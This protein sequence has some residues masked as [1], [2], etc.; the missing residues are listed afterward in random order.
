MELLPWPCN[1]WETHS[2]A[3]S[4]RLPHRHLAQGSA[5]SP[6][7]GA[8]AQFALFA[9]QCVL[10]ETVLLTVI[11]AKV[12]AVES[13]TGIRSPYLLL[14]EHGMLDA[15]EGIYAQRHGPADAVKGQDTG[16]SFWRAV[17]EFNFETRV[18]VVR[19]N[20]VGSRGGHG[21]CGRQRKSGQVLSAIAAIRRS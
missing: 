11:H 4:P 10:F 7:A 17:C 3:R 14:L 21:G 20:I 12:S 9:Q 16:H 5:R 1:A 13:S 15:F 18:G 8:G 19:M 2:Q 6:V